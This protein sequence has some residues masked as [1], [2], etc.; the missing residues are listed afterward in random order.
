MHERIG[1]M[2]TQQ[3]VGNEECRDD[4]E[5]CACDAAAR[6]EQDHDQHESEYDVLG[7]YG[8]DARDALGCANA[9]E[10]EVTRGY[11][12]CACEQHVVE[13]HGLFGG[14]PSAPAEDE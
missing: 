4:G 6:F 11:E 9:L 8:I 2:R 1:E 7:V 5:D 14:T 3:D 10:R 13:R 12:T